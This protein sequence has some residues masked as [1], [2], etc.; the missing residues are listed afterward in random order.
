M[1]GHIKRMLVV[2]AMCS[3]VGVS[4]HIAYG[5]NPFKKS[6]W[7]KVGQSIKNAAQSAADWAKDVGDQ[8][9]KKL[10]KVSDCAQIVPL[11][12]AWASQ[13]AAYYVA[14]A[15]LTAAQQLQQADPVLTGLRAQVAALQ[16]KK[17]ALQG[18]QAAANL[19]LEATQALADATSAIVNGIGSAI[20]GASAVKKFAAKASIADLQAMKLPEFSLVVT[21]AGKDITV[22]KVPISFKSLA[23]FKKAVVPLAKSLIETISGGKVKKTDLDAKMPDNT[24]VDATGNVITPAASPTT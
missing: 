13:R 7:Q 23:D 6:D 16:A 20:Q 18:T 11:G 24:I 8:I 21:I 19:G 22:D 12:T 15:T 9:A 1:K 3:L 4:A 2:A 17:V 5:W 14:T 10:N